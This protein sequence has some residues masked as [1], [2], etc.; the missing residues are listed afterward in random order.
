MPVSLASWSTSRPRGA[1][2]VGGEQVVLQVLRQRRRLGLADVALGHDGQKQDQVAEGLVAEHAVEGALR[3]L[4]QVPEK[5]HVQPPEQLVQ[6]DLGD[7]ALQGLFTQIALVLRQRD[8][9]AEPVQAGLADEGFLARHA[10]AHAAFLGQRQLMGGKPGL[11]VVQIGGDGPV[12]DREL[13]GQRTDG[14]VAA[15]PHQQADLQIQ[16]PLIGAEFVLIGGGFRQKTLKQ[17]V[18]LPAVGQLNALSE[19]PG[20][21]RQLSPRQKFVDHIQAVADRTLRFAQL[22]GERADVDVVLLL[23]QKLQELQTCLI[24]FHE[25]SAFPGLNFTCI[26]VCSSGGCKGPRV[27]V[28]SKSK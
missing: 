22:R 18:G 15:V 14:N 1:V 12:G 28:T 11:H 20:E 24:Q 2:L 8:A 25:E 13:I 23:I 26:L 17:G 4:G 6:N 16:Q 19:F 9:L 27:Q 21:Q 10:Q 7:F 3:L 5:R